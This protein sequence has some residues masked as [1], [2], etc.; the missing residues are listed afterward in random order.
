MAVGRSAVPDWPDGLPYPDFIRGLDPAVPAHAAVMHEATGVGRGAGYTT[1]DV[2]FGKNV[3]FA[4]KRLNIGV[5]IYNLFNNDQVITYQ[6][7]FD[8]VDNAATTNVVEQWGQ[9]TSLLSP[10]FVRLS[11]QLDF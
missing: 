3:R 5:D 9:A 6:D 8:T 10:R 11:I 4:N 1:F 7:N 2:K